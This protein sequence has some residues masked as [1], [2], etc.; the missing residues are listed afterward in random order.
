MT[1]IDALPWQASLAVAFAYSFA[2]VFAEQLVVKELP[3]G[4]KVQVADKEGQQ[5]IVLPFGSVQLEAIWQVA[6]GQAIPFC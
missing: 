4:E 5:V 2:A 1:N 3:L 6:S